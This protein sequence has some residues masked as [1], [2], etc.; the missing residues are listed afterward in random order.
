MSSVEFYVRNVLKAATGEI[1]VVGVPNNG[2][3]VSVGDRFATR[4][5]L[6]RDDVLHGVTNAMRLNSSPIDLVV[7]KIDVMHRELPQVPHGVTAALSLSGNGL[8]HVVA[9]CFIR[10]AE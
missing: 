10:T 4:Y 9:G 6:D 7:D 1:L 5:E 8:E 3:A 2:E